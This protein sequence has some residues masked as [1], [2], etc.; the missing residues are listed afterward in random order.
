MQDAKAVQT[1]WAEGAVPEPIPPPR[2]A[3]AP[4][5]GLGRNQRPRRGRFGLFTLLVLFVIGVGFFYLTL[6]YSGR[7]VALPVLAVAEVERRLNAGL[8]GARLPPGS[9]VVLEAVEFSVDSD[10]VPA[11][12]LHDIRLINP[13][14]RSLLSLPMV[15]VTFDLQALVTGRIR[16][17]SLQLI[18][19]RLTVRRDLEG[20][21]DL[22]L[23]GLQDGAGP[24]SLGELMDAMERVLAAP[25][26]QDLVSI[27]AEDVTITLTDDRADRAWQMGDGQLSIRIAD[28]GLDALLGLSLLEGVTPAKAEVQLTSS[29]QDMSAKVVARVTDF[30]AKDIA[31][32]A[33]PLAFLRALDAPIS[34][35]LRGFIAPEGIV[36]GLEAD[37]AVGQG[38][39]SPGEGARPIGFDAANLSLNYDP[40]TARLALTDLRVESPSLRLRATGYGDLLGGAGE[41]AAAGAIPETILGQIDLAQ[42][43]IDPEGQFV[44]PVRFGQGALDLRL[45][46]QPFQLEIGQLALV[47]GDERL[48]LSGDVTTTAQGWD[49]ALDVT[50]NQIAAEKLLKVW[51]VSVLPRTRQWFDDNV[52][53]A[54]LSNVHAALRLDPTGQPRLNLAYEFDDTEVR[55]VRTLPPVLNARGHAVLDGKV[56]TAVLNQ[57]HVIAP[58]GG[59]IEANGTVFQIKDITQRPMLANIDL[60]T[61]S[62]L[63]A[64]LSLLDQEPFSFFSKAGQPYNLGDGQAEL[65]S[66]LLMPIKPRVPLEEVDFKV[67]G[68]IRDF[69]SPSLVAGR[70][71]RAPVVQVDVDTKGLTLSGKGSLDDMPVDLTYR[72]GFGPE[73]KGRARVDGTVILSDPVLRDFGIELPKGSVSGEGPAAI[74]LALVK[75]LPPQL[76]LTSTLSGLGLRL[77]ALGWRKAAGT[78]GALDMEVRLGPEPVVQSMRL[79]APGLTVE[80]RITTREGGGLAEG[81][82]SRVRAGDWLDAP[83][84]LTG[85]GAGRAPT[86]A[87][88]GGTLDLRRMPD[89]GGGTGGGGTT[90]LALDRLRISEG[91]ALTDFRGDFGGRGGLNGSFVA[92]VNGGAEIAGVVSPAKG[93]NAIRIT[94]RNAGAVMAAAGIFDKGRGGTL[95]MTL[96]SMG[97]DGH[98]RGRAKFAQLRV[99]GAPVLAEL[100]SALSVVGLL[101]QLGG[102]GLAF[103]TG[104][105]DFILTPQAVEISRGSAVGASL[106]ISFAGLYYTGSD[107][108]DLQ[109]VITPIYLV[110]GLGQIFSKRGEG[111]FG[112]NYR[113]T[114]NAD[115]PAVSVNP[116]S[117]LTPGMFR[118]IFRQPPPKLR[119]T[120]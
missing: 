20:R 73:Q 98:Y 10:F 79:A 89:G 6:A 40:I 58:E 120:E 55:L 43:M 4:R 37:L 51:P 52:G 36:A 39:L 42:V 112:F 62:S 57:G 23:A 103:N 75:G 53:Q 3:P 26:F 13:Q 104:E 114:G 84:V 46:L 91:I 69:I 5:R 71:L 9:A 102:A 47:E 70:I 38:S 96:V 100:L 1:E 67:T 44:E 41:P 82:F 119:F 77:D 35:Q 107:K 56:Y 68:Q 28:R 106:G 11:F 27:R 86:V 29:G 34:G 111:F 76:T 105:V 92:G 72:Q 45:R 78:E 109:G 113:L 21:F 108:I 33:P 12:R 87:V 32:I 83:V 94:S 16:P 18:G 65:R 15:Q 74:D 97:R 22:R 49:G 19:T 54:R 2:P 48:I 63:T 80:G 14:G 25:V 66:T 30:A 31:D 93:G 88:T 101:E 64:T 118:E 85:N 90:R 24:K 116:L 115:N 59:R 17:S 95:D 99:Q 61:Q 50:L 60:V 8:V 81:R 117:V 110:N 7:S